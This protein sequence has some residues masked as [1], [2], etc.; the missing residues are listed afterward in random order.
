M[1][2]TDQICHKRSHWHVL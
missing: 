2:A 1:A